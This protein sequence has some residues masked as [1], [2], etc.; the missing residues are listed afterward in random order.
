[1][2]KNKKHFR[3]CKN[4]DV[5]EI[6]WNDA[7]I[8]TDTQN[9]LKGYD[10]A[11]AKRDMPHRDYGVVIHLDEDFISITPSLRVHP[12]KDGDRSVG[13]IKHIGLG[14]VSKVEILRKAK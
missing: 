4:G 12:W 13:T 10:F 9:W 6:S 14:M 8:T 11:Q 3:P 5:V 1:M 7:I 2:K